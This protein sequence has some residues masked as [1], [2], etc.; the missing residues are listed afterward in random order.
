MGTKSNRSSGTQHNPRGVT[1]GNTLVDPNTGLPI[2]V[3]TDVTGT[4]RL[5]VDANLTVQNVQISAALDYQE[6]SVH[7]GDPNTNTTLKVNPDGSIDANIEVDAA[8][9]DNIG[10]KL[11]DRT[12]SPNDFNYSKRITAKTGTKNTDTTSMDVS[13]HDHFGN[14]LTDRNPFQVSTNYEK[15]I[16]VILNSAW[17]KLAVYDEVITSVSSNRNSITLS[18]KEDGNLIGEAFINFTS[19]LNWNF[20]LK[21]YLL[22]DDGSILL[23]D[24]DSELFLE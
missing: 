22:D 6:D 2:D 18:F 9:G 15:I 21:R 20:N 11:Q 12:L 24:N 5:A 8:D 7:I 13:I 1:Q 10:L 3:I 17:M 23:D 16:Q 4:K 14:E 19:D